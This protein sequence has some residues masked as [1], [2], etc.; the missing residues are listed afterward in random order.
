MFYI[1]MRTHGK[2]SEAYS[3]CQ[4]TSSSYI[5]LK[6]SLR[7]TQRNYSNIKRITLY[8]MSYLSELSNFHTVILHHKAY[9]SFVKRCR[10]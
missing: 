5:K 6:L 8:K 7:K 2:K 1:L 10:S 9:T 4:R 3:I